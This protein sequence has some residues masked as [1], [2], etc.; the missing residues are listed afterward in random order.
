MPRVSLRQVTLRLPPELH[1]LL[2]SEAGRRRLPISDY[3]RFCLERGFHA[4]RLDDQVGELRYLLSS[5]L[6]GGLAGGGSQATPATA[7]GSQA[8][9]SAGAKAAGKDG[10]G[11]LTA[12][13]VKQLLEAHLGPMR[14]TLDG[15]ARS[16]PATSAPKNDRDLLESVFVAEELLRSIA[17]ANR[18][19][20]VKEAQDRARARLAKVTG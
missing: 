6:A 16:A 2:A 9:P 4:E 17:A 19:T 13:A 10:H 7:G 20:L 11:A 3:L 8:G 12:E 14:R 1:N 15:L 5:A 18:P